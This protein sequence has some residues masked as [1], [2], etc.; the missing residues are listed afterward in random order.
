MDGKEA[1]GT[2]HSPPPEP[3]ILTQITRLPRHALW[4]IASFL[5]CVDLWALLNGIPELKIHFT[6]MAPKSKVYKSLWTTHE[7][8][9]DEDWCPELLEG[10][11]PHGANI[12]T[13]YVHNASPRDETYP[14]LVNGPSSGFR[15]RNYHI[16]DMITCM[17]KLKTVIIHRT[18]FLRYGWALCHLSH[19][20]SFTLSDAVEFHSKTFHNILKLMGTQSIRRKPHPLKELYL[21]DLPNIAIPT[22]APA[23]SK[24]FPNLQRLG[25][26]NKKVY[27]LSHQIHWILMHIQE[28]CPSF[29]W[30]D[31]HLYNARLEWRECA[32]MFKWDYISKKNLVKGY[33]L[34][35]IEQGAEK[36]SIL[37]GLWRW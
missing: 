37:Q 3:R 12:Q 7:I 11:I 35:A 24:A 5:S 20:T 15:P 33:F 34:P 31:C 25:L 8:Y 18:K 28:L 1:S 22:Y 6:G 32:A 29:Q 27:Y 4:H 19:L 14:N 23:I 13:L 17:R 2:P 36:P 10:L 30:F 16:E 26:V 21:Q 9:S